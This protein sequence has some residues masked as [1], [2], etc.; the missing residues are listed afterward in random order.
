MYKESLLPLEWCPLFQ[1]LSF[2][3][4]SLF[5]PSACY[6]HLL[7]VAKYCL[8]SPIILT[9]FKQLFRSDSEFNCY[10]YDAQMVALHVFQ[11]VSPDRSE[12]SFVVPSWFKL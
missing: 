9:T 3:S 4:T 7:Y 5:P 8:V 1:Y 11:A 6:S 12:E 2:K 10:K